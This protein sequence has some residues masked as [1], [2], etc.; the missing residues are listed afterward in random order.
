[1]SKVGQKRLHSTALPTL[2]G[3]PLLPLL[4]TSETNCYNDGRRHENFLGPYIVDCHTGQI[5]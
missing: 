4:I 1:M 5:S 3:N 2:I